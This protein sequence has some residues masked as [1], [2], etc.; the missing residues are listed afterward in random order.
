M[1]AT[2]ETE[3]E[4]NNV[5]AGS[6][7]TVAP[8]ATPEA[9]TT[10]DDARVFVD[11]EG[12]T[13]SDWVEVSV[14]G[15]VHGTVRS[16]DEGNAFSSVYFRYQLAAGDHVVRFEDSNGRF[17]EKVITVNSQVPPLT[18]RV[19]TG[20]TATADS[21]APNEPAPNGLASGIVDG[22]RDTYWHSKWSAPV[23]TFP[24]TVNVD[25]GKVCEL[26]WLTWVPRQNNDNGQVSNFTIAFSQD[27]TTWTE[28]EAKTLPGGRT[29]TNVEVDATARYVRISITDNHA[30]T[31][32]FATIGELEF[33][34][35]EPGEAEPTPEPVVPAVWTPPATCG[36][37]TTA[38]V[39]AAIEDQTGQVGTELTVDVQATDGLLGRS[40]R[41]PAGSPARP[42]RPARTR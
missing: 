39:I 16:D 8:S 31:D 6:L 15:D 3:Q 12:L 42:P 35:L 26:D 14:D 23:D 9:D 19:L 25:L 32:E 29:A 30:T 10:R 33:R 13:P 18:G 21:E 34:G 38:P 28:P 20:A 40:T 24:H 4:R 41:P 37:D 1:P 36:P 5:Y 27:N 17:V 7:Y 2:F 22:N 11:I